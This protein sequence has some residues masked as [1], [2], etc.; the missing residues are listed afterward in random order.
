MR[1]ESSYKMVIRLPNGKKKKNSQLKYTEER[2]MTWNHQ[3]WRLCGLDSIVI[4]CNRAIKEFTVHKISEIKECL[5]GKVWACV[6]F[7][8]RHQSIKTCLILNG[9]WR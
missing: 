1:R 6:F 2:H 4:I 9:W 8:Q 5:L 7:E 3:S